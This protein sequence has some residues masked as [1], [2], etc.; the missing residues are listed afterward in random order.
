MAMPQLFKVDSYI[1]CRETCTALLLIKIKKRKIFI[2]IIFFSSNESV[3]AK[4]KEKN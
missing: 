1:L 2:K 3:F 4:G